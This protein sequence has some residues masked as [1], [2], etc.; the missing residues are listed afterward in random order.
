MT[1]QNWL[2]QQL[3]ELVILNEGVK[4]SLDV[5]GG[6]VNDFMSLKGI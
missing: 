1:V 2:E 6:I 5:T 4:N 3:R